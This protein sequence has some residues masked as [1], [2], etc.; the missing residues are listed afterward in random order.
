MAAKSR[1]TFWNSFCSSV[2]PVDARKAGSDHDTCLLRESKQ[3]AS[4]TTLSIPQSISTCP[5]TPTNRSGSLA[6]IIS[7][8]LGAIMNCA[9]RGQRALG[10]GFPRTK[11][12]RG[13]SYPCLLSV[14]RQGRGQHSPRQLSLHL[15]RSVLQKYNDTV[16]GLHKGDTRKQ[17]MN[18][19]VLWKQ[20]LKFWLDPAFETSFFICT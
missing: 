18:K 2:R 1:A 5:L 12:T 11:Q 9:G 7:L 20:D 15:T 4:T 8:F 13:P 19:E 17:A 10:G 16:L 14:V 3:K 6:Q